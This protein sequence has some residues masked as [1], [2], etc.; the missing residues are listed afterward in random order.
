MGDLQSRQKPLFL[1]P[2]G[3]DEAVAIC[4]FRLLWLRQRGR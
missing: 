2:K 3:D 1:F 4:A